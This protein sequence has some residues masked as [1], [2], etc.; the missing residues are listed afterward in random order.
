[1]VHSPVTDLYVV[2]PHE[3][4]LT[5]DMHEAGGRLTQYGGTSAT[6]GHQPTAL[7][8]RSIRAWGRR[9]Y[10]LVHITT[11][12][13]IQS[14]CGV[15]PRLRIP[16]TIPGGNPEYPDPLR[17]G[18]LTV[19]MICTRPAAFRPRKPFRL[20]HIVY[21][22]RPGAWRANGHVRHLASG[23]SQDSESLRHPL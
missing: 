19:V 10:N 12:V 17:G 23:H 6:H 7:A 3:E 20:S 18:V 21:S 16:G 14:Q 8:T 5:H 11:A 2:V 15:I 13:K 1:M 22:C 9:C 4:Y